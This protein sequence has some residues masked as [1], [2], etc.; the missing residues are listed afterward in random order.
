M[1]HGGDPRWALHP[2]TWLALRAELDLLP[3]DARFLEL[4]GGLGSLLAVARGLRVTA[5]D[6][7]PEDLDRLRTAVGSLEIELVHAPLE[8][9]PE[10]PA[11]AFDR[12]PEQSYDAIFVDGPSLGR[13]G[14][15][16]D[17]GLRLLRPAAV[18]IFDDARRPE[19]AAV[20][21]E[22]ARRLGRPLRLS[23]PT[24]VLRAADRADDLAA[25][26]ISD[27]SGAALAVPARRLPPPTPPE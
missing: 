13:E 27:G 14:I 4:G 3:R 18:I 7:R 25:A 26:Q 8:P 15:L 20:A 9:T 10:G 5:V 1:R 23:G 19:E 6:D 11:Y 16:S 22:T 2:E 12:I 21:A 24:A 17:A